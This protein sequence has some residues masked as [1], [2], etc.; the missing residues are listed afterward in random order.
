M[1]FFSSVPFLGDPWR[2]A[3]TSASGSPAVSTAEEPI[4]ISDGFHCSDLSTTNGKVDSTVLAVQQEAL[5]SIQGWLADFKPTNGSPK[6]PHR[7]SADDEREKR[8][9]LRFER[10]T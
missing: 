4:G 10:E 8:R 3:T 6:S 1:F 7:R 9:V 5:K 2:E